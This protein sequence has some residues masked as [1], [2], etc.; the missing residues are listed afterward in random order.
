[1]AWEPVSPRLLSARFYSKGRNITIIQGYA[2]TNA[3][4][5]EEKA[6]FY[7]SLQSLYDRSPRRDIKIVMGDMNAKVGDNNTH[8]ESIMGKHRVGTCNE[9]GEIFMDFC[10]FNGLVIGGTIYPHKNIQKT[11]WTSPD[12]KT[13]NQI[14]HFTIDRK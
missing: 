2:P 8:R 4:E 14:Y 13:N 3:A 5:E 7:S 12:G 11:T 10:S 6:D 9:N 1:M